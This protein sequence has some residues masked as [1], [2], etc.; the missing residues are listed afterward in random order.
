MLRACRT[1]GAETRDTP[2]AYAIRQMRPP[3]GESA[4]GVMFSTAMR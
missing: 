3:F 4:Y 2:N 1:R